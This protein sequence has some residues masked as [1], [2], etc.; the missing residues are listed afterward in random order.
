VEIAYFDRGPLDAK[1]LI[2]GGYRSAYWYNGHIY[3][4]EMARG[5]DAFRLKPSAFLSQNEIDAALLA[6]RNEFNAQAQPKTVWPAT[7]VVARAY[8]DQLRRTNAISL[9]RTRAVNDALARVARIRSSRDRN[10][11]VVLKEVDSLRS[12]LEADGKN[13]ADR[14]ATRLTALADVL[15]NIT[16]RLR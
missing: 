14:D 13:A 15:K 1:D 2:V 9:E 6:E 10:A 4:S 16:T 3:A 12:Q 7:A 5:L 11:A 8:I